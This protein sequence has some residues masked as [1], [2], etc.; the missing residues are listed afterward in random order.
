MRMNLSTGGQRVFAP[1]FLIATLLV[2]CAASTPLAR[3]PDFPK[4][5][6]TLGTLAVLADVTSLHHKSG[7]IQK[8][9][10]PE[11]QQFGTVLLSTLADELKKKGY[12]VEKMILATVGWTLRPGTQV[13]VIGTPEDRARDSLPLAEP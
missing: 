4:M 9:D 3:Y 13:F 12:V 2:G 5:K 11:S 6:P 1:V 7:S 8:L 10:V